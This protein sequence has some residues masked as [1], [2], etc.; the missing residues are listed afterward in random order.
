MSYTSEYYMLESKIEGLNLE[1]LRLEKEV[2]TL[3][4]LVK[5]LLEGKKI[6]ENIK[7]IIDIWRI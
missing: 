5:Y 4:K 7:N 6:P 2:L 3:K 1:K